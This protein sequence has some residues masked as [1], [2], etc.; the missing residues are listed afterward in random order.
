MCIKLHTSEQGHKNLNHAADHDIGFQAKRWRARMKKKKV[1]KRLW[2][3]GLVY[4][5]EMLLRI[6]CGRDRSTIYE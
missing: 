2:N 5:S 6:A 3:F 1:L 4:E